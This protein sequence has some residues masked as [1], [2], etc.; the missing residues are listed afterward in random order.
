M[1]RALIGA[2]VAAVL[3]LAPSVEAVSRST[4]LDATASWLA[5][6]PVGVKCYE[7][8]EDASPWGYG[9]WGYVKRPLKTAGFMHLDSRLCAGALDVN[10]DLPAWQRAIGVEILVHEA[11]HLRRWSA[12]ANEGRAQ[13]EAIRHWK[14][15]AVALGATEETVEE[16]WPIALADHYER[17][18]MVS[19]LTGE[20]PYYDPDCVVPELLDYDSL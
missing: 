10:G 7:A 8:D 14:V 1:K 6:R 15:V 9:A 17:S 3:L 12:A 20:R 16:L 4:T 18:N 11:Y 5:M 19:W 2:V 13:C